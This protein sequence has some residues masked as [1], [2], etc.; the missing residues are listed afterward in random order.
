M[1]ETST[2][3]DRPELQPLHVARRRDGLFEA[4][5]EM[6]ADLSGWTVLRID[7]GATTLVCERK[8]GLL[9]GATR[10]TIRVEGPEDLP[11][12]TLHLRA[13]AQGGLFKNEKAVVA[14][15]MKPFIRRV[16]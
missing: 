1:F 15:F 4:A 13:E 14:E 2:S 7:D 5:K 6:V 12:A 11:S 3:H 9:G 8:G 10:V 16:C